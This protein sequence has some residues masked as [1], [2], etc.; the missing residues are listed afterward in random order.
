MPLPEYATRQA[1]KLVAESRANLAEYQRNLMSAE[2]VIFQLGER[3]RIAEEALRVIEKQGEP[4]AA[5]FA[6]ETRARLLRVGEQ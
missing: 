3:L 4:K 6:K 1:Q 2:A 5:A